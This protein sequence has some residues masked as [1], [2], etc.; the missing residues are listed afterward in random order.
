MDPNPA[1][2]AAGR[3]PGASVHA[4]GLE[5]GYDVHGAGPPMILL[6]G[7]SSSGREDYAAQIPG[8]QKAFRLYLPDARGHATTRWEP[9]PGLHAAD[10]VADL[11]AFADALHLATFH[12]VGFSMGAG[13]A[14]RFATQHPDRLRTLVVIGYS[15][16]REPRTSVARRVLDPARIER[17]DPAWADELERRHGPVQGH[18]AWRRLVE[19]VVAD[20]AGQPP[21]ELAALRS[22]EPPAMVV[23]GDRDPFTPV[24]Q[25]WNLQRQLPDA[26]LLVVP[27]C[28]HQVT[29]HRPGIFNE[30]MAAFYRST[31]AAA[32]R[33]AQAAR[34][35]VGAKVADTQPG[36]PPADPDER[37][38]VEGSLGHHAVDGDD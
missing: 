9:S 32:A 38:V 4:N 29:A 22:V 21:I 16:D 7:A 11:L 18:G 36:L 30:A 27:G 17:D 31:E 34:P 15:L 28:G 3:P 33:R 23:C 26:R 12:L 13:T 6:H 10:L 1:L 24:G 37:T 35:S 2:G 19:A 20:V 8:F 25:A 5:I 14:L